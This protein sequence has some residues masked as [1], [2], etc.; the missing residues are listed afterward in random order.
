MTVAEPWEL[1]SGWRWSAIRDIATEVSG[2]WG[3]D[4]GEGEVDVRV[5]RS[6]EMR[7]RV[8][9]TETAAL[10]SMTRKAVEKTRLRDGDV[11]INKSSGSARLVGRASLVAGV[12]DDVFGYS[13]FVLRLRPVT[14]VDGGYL[15]AFLA[16]DIG[17]RLFRRLNRTTSGLR[18]LVMTR[19]RRVPVPFPTDALVQ[20][21]L[22]TALGEVA[23]LEAAARELERLG[24]DL[25]TAVL[26]DGV[27]DGTP[28]RPVGGWSWRPIMDVADPIRG[29]TFKPEH[30]VTSDSADAVQ[31]LTTASVQREIDWDTGAWLP[32]DRVASAK[33]LRAGDLLIST[34]NSKALVGKVALVRR[35]PADRVTLGAFVYGLR[36]RDEFG[37][38]PALL[39]AWLASAPVQALLRQRSRQTTNIANLRPTVINALRV[40]CPLEA[41]SAHLQRVAEASR[42]LDEQAARLRETAD[43][44]RDAVLAEHVN[45]SAVSLVA[46]SAVDSGGKL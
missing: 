11:L 34:S 10:R 23:A 40:P 46:H 16:S 37:V 13:N 21:A 19:Y 20:S 6:T 42:E 4:P 9:N 30:V 7:E 25:L 38:F 33:D 15:H 5:V 14:G 36:P 8:V 24:R 3:K 27:G 28:E 22:M 29:V 45:A 17:Q 12:G 32:P 18:N 26:V 1:P 2:T 39:H 35:L 43:A 41:A 44:L 31:V